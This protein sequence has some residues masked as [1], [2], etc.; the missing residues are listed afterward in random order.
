MASQVGFKHVYDNVRRGRY[1]T[2]EDLRH[3][4][5]NALENE[6]AKCPSRARGKVLTAAL[7]Y[8]IGRRKA[9]IRIGNVLF[10]L[11]VPPRQEEGITQDK[12][13]QLDDYMAGF[14]KKHKAMTVY[15]VVTNGWFLEVYERSISNPLISGEFL[16][17][18]EFLVNLLCVK[19]SKIDIFE[20]TDFTSIFGLW[21]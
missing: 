12:R 21:R 20:A 5:L 11:D 7:E 15:G 8:L 18:A 4:F 3:D 2:H 1:Q 13:C 10:E 17:G 19:L 14:I 16:R 9:D 6:I